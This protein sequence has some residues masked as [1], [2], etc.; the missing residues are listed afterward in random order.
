M[1][2]NTSFQ[3]VTLQD[4]FT[5]VF[6]MT[7]TIFFLYFSLLSFNFCVPHRFIYSVL[8]VMLNTIAQNISEQTRKQAKLFI[9]KRKR[10]KFICKGKKLNINVYTKVKSK[11]MNHEPFK[12]W[13]HY[14]KERDNNVVYSFQEITLLLLFA[15]R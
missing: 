3:Q 15:I 5:L 10:I 1:K 6:V 11:K 14:R 7:F 9:Q 8:N 13:N 4:L 12:N 2:Q